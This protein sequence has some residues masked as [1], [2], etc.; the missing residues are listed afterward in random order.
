[1]QEYLWTESFSLL[2]ASSN[3][4]LPSF[5]VDRAQ[6][7]RLLFLRLLFQILRVWFLLLSCRLSDW[8]L[9]LI[10]AGEQIVDDFIEQIFDI[11]TCL[12]RD[13]PIMLSL[14]VG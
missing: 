11:G 3:L 2:A 4:I 9:L 14:L 1:L 12:G 10:L 8:I 5:R 13:L 6:L 7:D